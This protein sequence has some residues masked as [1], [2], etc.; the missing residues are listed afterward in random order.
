[1]STHP[2]AHRYLRYIWNLTAFGI[3]LGLWALPSAQATTGGSMAPE[4]AVLAIVEVPRPQH[5]PGFAIRRK[6]RESIPE[7]EGLSGLEFK[8]Y[9]LGTWAPEN[10]SRS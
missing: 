7:Y 6:M 5:V 8:A 3:L 2:S 4:A 10:I 9:S 1:M